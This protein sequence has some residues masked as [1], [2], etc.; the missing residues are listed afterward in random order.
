MRNLYSVFHPVVVWLIPA[1]FY[2]WSGWHIVDN[3]LTSIYRIVN[4]LSW[5]L[6]LD[7]FNTFYIE[8]VVVSEIRN[9]FDLFFVFKFECF[10]VDDFDTLRTSLDKTSKD[11]H[12]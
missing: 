2:N 8:D 5:Q 12:L 4:E 9:S 10:P 1:M 6:Q 11:L 3:R 7:A